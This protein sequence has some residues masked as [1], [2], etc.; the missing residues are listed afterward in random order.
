MPETCYQEAAVKKKPWVFGKIIFPLLILLTS[1]AAQD[2]YG[3]EEEQ[4]EPKVVIKDGM[5]SLSTGDCPL[6]V[7]LENIERQ[8]K[9]SFILNHSL[10]QERVSLAFRSMPFLKGLKKILSRM[11]YLLFFDGSSNLVQVIVIRQRKGYLPVIRSPSIRS[12][13]TFGRRSQGWRAT[14]PNRIRRANTV[15]PESLQNRP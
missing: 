14:S 10:R 7:L 6:S 9:V 5:M 13:R 4:G 15:S 11:S 2:L 12:P 3:A 8:S 1:W